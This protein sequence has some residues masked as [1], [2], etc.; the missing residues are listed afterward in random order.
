M[1]SSAFGLF[2]L[3]MVSQDAASSALVQ[4]EQAQ[5]NAYAFAR[6]NP[7]IHFSPT[8]GASYAMSQGCIPHIMTGRPA[9]DFFTTAAI[10]RGPRIQGQYTVTNRVTLREDAIGSCTVVVTAG[11]PEG[12]RT[13][14]LNV[15]DRIT[16]VRIVQSD[17]GAGSADSNGSFRQELHCITLNGQPLYLLMSSSSERNRPRLMASLGRDTDGECVRRITR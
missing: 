10:R 5:T 14:M 1:M 6:P 7:G 11:D 15:F 12:L 3:G 16:A 17:S 8:G 9:T 2:L 13:E 4:A